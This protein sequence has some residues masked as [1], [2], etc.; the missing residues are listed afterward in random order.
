MSSPDEHPWTLIE[1]M[2]L[3]AQTGDL[4][5]LQSQLA[6]WEVEVADES[7][8]QKDH[9]WIDPTVAKIL[10]WGEMKSHTDKS[11]SVYQL[12]TRLLVQAAGTNQVAT[13]KYLI[14][15]R[16][17]SITPI[18]AQEALNGDAFDMLEVFLDYGWN[19]NDEVREN[20]CPVLGCAILDKR[21]RR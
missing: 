1:E 7:V 12:L 19:I 6:R 9:L 21:K 18:I 15:K 20:L 5:N 8:T 14:D 16:G 13:V 2:E 11:E 17:G 3:S 10:D 4:P